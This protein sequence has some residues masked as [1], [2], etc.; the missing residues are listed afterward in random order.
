MAKN[1]YFYNTQ[2]I[3]ELKELIR[4]G[5]PIK[6]IAERECGKYNTSAQA[7]AIKMYNLAKT[8]TK[9]REWTGKRV[10]R[11]KAQLAEARPTQNVG[12]DVPTGTTFEGTPKKVTI[13]PDHFRIYF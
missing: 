1:N 7:L 6:R 10:R 4:T 13:Y 9:V 5:E 2:D 11:T 3:K 12:I 8:T